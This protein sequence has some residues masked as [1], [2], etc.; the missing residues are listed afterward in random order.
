MSIITNARRFI[1]GKKAAVSAALMLATVNAQ[2]AL[3]TTTATSQTAADST[4]YIAVI[5]GYAFDIGI[6]AGLILGTMAFIVVVKN[7]VGTYS[8][9]ANGK[10]T[11]GDLAMHGGMGVLLLAFCV[12]MLNEAAKVLAA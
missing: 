10:K 8:E 1:S 6:A 2:A 7:A 4:D 5:K 3:P 12:F 9:I 11:W